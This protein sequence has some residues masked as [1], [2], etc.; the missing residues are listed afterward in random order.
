MTQSDKTKALLL[1]QA[2]HIEAIA[3]DNQRKNAR[4]AELEQ[5]LAKTERRWRYE[6]DMRVALELKLAA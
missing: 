1:R 6:R 2:A 3:E 4:I 5:A